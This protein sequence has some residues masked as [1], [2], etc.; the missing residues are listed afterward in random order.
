MTALHEERV[1]KTCTKCKTEKPLTEFNR[2]A[3]SIDGLQR[4]CRDCAKAHWR[5]YDARREGVRA[6]VKALAHVDE[7]QIPMS[8]LIPLI[9][10]WKLENTVAKLKESQ[11]ADEG[12]GWVNHLSRLSGIH[13]RT[14]SRIMSGGQADPRVSERVVTWVTF[15]TADKLTTAMDCN[16]EWNEGGSL[17]P[18]YGPLSVKKY[19]RHLEGVECPVHGAPFICQHVPGEDTWTSTLRLEGVE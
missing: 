4:Y 15:D 8:V 5:I 17:N 14:I 2:Q 7:P 13:G 18:W 1:A 11:G 6:P 9:E 19:E 10:R 16:Q 3:L 12:S